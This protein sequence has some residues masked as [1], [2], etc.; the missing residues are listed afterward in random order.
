M[1]VFLADIKLRPKTGSSYRPKEAMDTFCMS[2]CKNAR[3]T[4][5]II[6]TLHGKLRR[7]ELRGRN[8]QIVFIVPTSKPNKS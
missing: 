2:I 3:P 8:F 7:H 5:F 1:D 6:D 4:R